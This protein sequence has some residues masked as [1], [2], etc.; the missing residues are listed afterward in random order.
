M[1][2]WLFWFGVVD[3]LVLLQLQRAVRGLCASNPTHK[4]LDDAHKQLRDADKRLTETLRRLN[5]AH[6]RL[7]CVPGLCLEYAR[8]ACVKKR[9]RFVFWL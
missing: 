7:N 1:N 3:N 5:D 8:D 2:H 6:K 4:C 9:W